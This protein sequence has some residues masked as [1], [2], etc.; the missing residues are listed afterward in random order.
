MKARNSIGRSP[1][2]QPV[3]AGGQ[4]HDGRR[5]GRD[6][7]ASGIHVQRRH[8]QASLRQVAS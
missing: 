6:K 4:E 2:T 8:A 3:A 7:L 1:C 5:A